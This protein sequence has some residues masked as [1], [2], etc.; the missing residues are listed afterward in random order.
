LR[1]VTITIHR[2]GVG[3]WLVWRS[4]RLEALADAPAAF[5][6]TLAEWVDAPDD[7]W[8]ARIRDVPL[9]LIA[10]LDD[11]PVG[12]VGATR[13]G[14]PGAVELISMWVSPAARGAGMG[15]ALVDAVISWAAS[16]GATQVE[17]SVKESN[18]PALPLYVRHGFP[19]IGAGDDEDELRMI[20]TIP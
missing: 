3:D 19:V 5:G 13:T 9:N 12:Q 8:R 7:R 17:L 14:R 1:S 6:S 15:D 4:V 2:L 11:R 20:R 18:G 16:E 10:R